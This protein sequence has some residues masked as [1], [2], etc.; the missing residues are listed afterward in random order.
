MNGPIPGNNIGTNFIY[1]L[2]C[3]TICSSKSIFLHEKS[4]KNQ[5]TMLYHVL[6]MI[7]FGTGHF[8]AGINIVAEKDEILKLENIVHGLVY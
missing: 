5:L 3:K 8:L 6:N 4:K 2:D 1:I 7:S